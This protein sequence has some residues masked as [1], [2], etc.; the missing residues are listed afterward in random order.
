M[1][2]Y[3][4]AVSLGRSQPG[5][6]DDVPAEVGDG[7]PLAADQ[8]AD[9]R[10]QGAPA[11]DQLALDDGGAAHDGLHRLEECAE[12]GFFQRPEVEAFRRVCLEKIEKFY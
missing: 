2:D 11:L 4:G 6:L 1:V 7:V 10:G 9:A 3:R 12:D 8:L 5:V